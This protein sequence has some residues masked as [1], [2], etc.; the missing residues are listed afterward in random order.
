MLFLFLLKKLEK[1]NVHFD[2]ENL[3]ILAKSIQEPNYYNLSQ[4]ILQ[5]FLS[6][7]L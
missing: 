6:I 7:Q 5:L 1:T 4:F 3:L 2:Y